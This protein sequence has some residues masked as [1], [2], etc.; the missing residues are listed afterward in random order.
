MAEVQSECR[1]QSRPARPAPARPSLANKALWCVGVGLLANAAVILVTH[2]CPV[3]ATELR[4]DQAAFGQATPAERMIG[5]RGLFMMPAQLGPNTYG[6]YLMD[7]DSQTIT[8]YRA[9]PDNSRFKLMAARSFR[10]DR[11][12]EDVNNETPT[13]KEVQK[14]IEA[15]RQREA[16]EG[17]KPEQ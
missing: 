8:V 13:P 12:L 7:A 17:K 2:F 10:Y 4:I 1:V 14:L 5:A 3:G 6:L 11:F 15:Q 9:L 16:L